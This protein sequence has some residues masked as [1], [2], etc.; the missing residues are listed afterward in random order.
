MIEQYQRDLREE[1]KEITVKPE[2]RS[3]SFK[4]LTPV[5]VDPSE[6]VDQEVEP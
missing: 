2:K 6:A 4:I 3:F 1:V 5:H